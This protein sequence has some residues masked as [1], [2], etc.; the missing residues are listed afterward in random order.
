M[1]EYEGYRSNNHSMLAFVCGA[2]VGASTALL[3]APMRGT[4]M[5]ANLNER[6]RQGRDRIRDYTRTGRDWASGRFTQAASVSRSALHRATEAVDTAVDR[7][8]TA[9][10]QGAA[11]AHE[12]TERTRS[13]INRGLDTTRGTAHDVAGAAEK[14]GEQAGD[15]AS[16]AREQW[17]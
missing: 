1:N 6:A 5:R 15:A 3:F 10:S 8:Q 13:A 4:D 9:V 14:M 11:R 17:S 2:L 16:R 7:A 12:V